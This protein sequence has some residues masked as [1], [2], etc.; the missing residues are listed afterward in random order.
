MIEAL[1]RK[2]FD[3][4]PAATVFTPGRVNLIGEHT[5]YNGG[6]VLPTA[7]PLGVRLAAVPRTD[8]RVRILSNG[9]DG[10]AERTLSDTARDHW[11][12][13]IVGALQNARKDGFGPNGADVVVATD[14][15]VGAGLSSSAAVTVGTFDI[16]Q[17]LSGM[18]RSRR[19]IAVMARRVENDFIGVPC[20]IMDQMAVAIS[21]PSQALSL[22]TKT[23][24]Y[25]LV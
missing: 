5:D 12:D 11:S 10:L 4:D 7:L 24:N 13:Y 18:D 15:P 21:T 25:E 1:F 16:A 9:F 23:L 14:L 8:G 2:T 3:Q 22:D 20:G 19:D 6:Q 17:A